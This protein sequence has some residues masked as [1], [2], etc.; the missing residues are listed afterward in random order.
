MDSGIPDKLFSS[1]RLGPCLLKNR[2]VALPVFTGYAHPDGRVS[3]LMID[4][5]ARLA[6][7][8]AAMVVVAN[9]AVSRDGVASSFNL[10]IDGDEF[11]PGL[12]RLAEAIKE[13]G[14]LA[15]I[16]LNHAGRFGKTDQPLLPSP[17]DTS[18][19]TFN[20][21]SLKDFMNFFPLEKRFRLTRH[22]L[23]KIGYWR[24]AMT[25]SD[26]ERIK[27]A[28]A[29]AAERARRVG[30]DLIELH[31]ASGYLLN[32]FLSPSTHRNSSGESADFHTRTAFPLE[33]VRAVKERI[34]EVPLGYRLIMREWVPEGI[35]LP[36]ALQWAG[37][38]Q[39]EGIAYLSASVASFNSMFS[40]AVMKKMA[41][42]GYLLE[43]VATLTSEVR[44][45]TVISGRIIRPGLAESI[46]SKGIADLI[47]LGRP[48]RADF[49]WL[50]KAAYRDKTIDVCINCNACLKRVVLEQGFNCE[51]WPAQARERTN[52]EHKLLTRMFK[53]LWVLL[54]R[55]DLA[56][57]R[58]A[59]PLILPDKVYLPAR[60]TPTILFLE[61]GEK[62]EI[63]DQE[64]VVFHQWGEH[65][66]GRI[67]LYHGRLQTVIRLAPDDPARVL[68]TEILQGGHGIIL[69]CRNRNQIW[70][71]HVPYSV[72]GKV[73][74]LIGSNMDLTRICVPVDLSESTLLGLMFL[75]RSMMFKPGHEF[76]FVHIL[77]GPSA[78]VIQRW[79]RL[80]EIAGLKQDLPLE[81]IF[82][83]GEVPEAL[84]RFIKE[85]GYGTVIMGKR[86][87]SGIKRRLLGSVS[88]RVL[89]GLV[90]QTLILID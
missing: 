29:D 14:A 5:Y 81:L 87:L 71:D 44:V 4:H 17:L 19:L 36:E 47:G 67:G 46:L 76:A 63:S 42:P 73:V 55:N 6:D 13:R 18:N 70:R 9:A 79:Q 43:D 53:G 78:P 72:R 66:L 21:A 77:Q 45:P 10:R 22:F 52:L 31:G 34:P 25:A 59:L 26:R 85:G 90:D 51:R 64:K 48:L 37:L 58:S 57:F 40:N 50:K 74:I 80:K 20:I 84:L 23:K 69:L 54:D 56:L 82:S 49:H 39:T 60:Y 88:A 15:C 27:T 83:K 24:R 75:S 68:Q 1:F 86:G 89:Q 3:T 41:R 62:S 11:L 65:L 28:F 61:T 16:Q 32:Q 2:L 33:V 12:T 38:L 35:E 7:S 30:F 8:G